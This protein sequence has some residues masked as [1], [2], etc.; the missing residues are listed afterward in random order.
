MYVNKN[1]S[2]IIIITKKD[3]INHDL[4][5]MFWFDSCTLVD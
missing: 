2:K 1:I 5:I 4:N 3:M